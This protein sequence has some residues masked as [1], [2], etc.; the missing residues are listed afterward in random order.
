MQ[1]EKKEKKEELERAK[2]LFGT[3]RGQYIIGQA[4]RIAYNEMNKAEETQ[5]E[6]SNMQ[7]MKLLGEQI[8]EIGWVAELMKE[9]FD[10]NK[11]QELIYETKT[12]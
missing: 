2:A 10:I 11:M 7:D 3:F 4:L 9:S 12:K 5:K 1:K 6:H 8:F